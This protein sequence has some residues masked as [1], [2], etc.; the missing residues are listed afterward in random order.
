MKLFKVTKE[1]E[2]QIGY[3]RYPYGDQLQQVKY[4]LFDRIVISAL[5]K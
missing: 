1:M 4:S 5:A 3:S 2:I